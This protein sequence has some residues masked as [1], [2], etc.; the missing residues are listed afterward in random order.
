M[1][2]TYIY[3]SHAWVTDFFITHKPLSRE[4]CY[5]S[6]CEEYD[7]LIGV[8]DD[9]AELARKLK[10]LFLDGCDVLPSKEY[11]SIRDKYCHPLLRQWELQRLEGDT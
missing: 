1:E 8:Y 10:W 7:T 3:Q 11:D 4:T 5:C 9:E 6:A 2:K